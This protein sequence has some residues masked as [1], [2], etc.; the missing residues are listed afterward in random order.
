MRT[1]DTKELFIQ[2]YYAQESELFKK[3]RQTAARNKCDH[4]I[5]APSESRTLQLLVELCEA[6]KIVEIGCLYGLSCLSMASVASVEHIWTLEKNPENAKIAQSFFSESQFA[7]K[8]KLIEGDAH[9][10]L[11]K[12]SQEGPFDLVFVDADK[13]GYPEY[14]NWAYKSLRSG[15]LVVCDNTFLGGAVWGEHVERKTQSQIQAMLKVHEDLSSSGRWI[16]HTLPSF[17]GLTIGKKVPARF[18]GT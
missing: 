10:S 8:I 16:S 14:V 1:Q 15:G 12:I 17:D 5:V 11:E 6:K 3:L 18:S 4:M 13:S 7:H 2:K 9:H